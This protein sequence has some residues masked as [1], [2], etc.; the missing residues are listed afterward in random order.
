MVLSGC[1]YLNVYLWEG[2]LVG[3]ND[4]GLL[5]SALISRI[6]SINLPEFKYPRGARYIL[7][8]RSSSR[9]LRRRPFVILA[10]LH[11]GVTDTASR[12]PV[13][14]TTST[15][16]DRP[17][18]PYLGEQLIWGLLLEDMT[19]IYNDQTREDKLDV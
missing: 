1:R 9:D 17:E 12:L 16:Q 11:Y 6:S 4:Q 15:M 3:F 8:W 19:G 14:H 10:G 18:S 5:T 2:L 13:F 7:A